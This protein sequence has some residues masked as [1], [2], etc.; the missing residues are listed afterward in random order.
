VSPTDFTIILPRNVATLEST[1]P[2]FASGCQSF[3]VLPAEFQKKLKE[4]SG[5]AGGGRIT[6]SAMAPDAPQPTKTP[7]L[8][9]GGI[10]VIHLRSDSDVSRKHL[11]G[12]VE[13]VKSGD[14]EAFVSLGDLLAFMDRHATEASDV[15]QE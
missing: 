12:R 5:L 1:L 3:G 4:I 10:F 13:H 2:N 14:S 8:T 7:I 9:P 11:I 6:P 15:S